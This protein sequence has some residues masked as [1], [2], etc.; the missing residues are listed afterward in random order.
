M[1]YLIGFKNFYKCYNVPPASTTI[2]KIPI[3]FLQI[4]QKYIEIWILT[5]KIIFHSK[6]K[7][8]T[9]SL[10]YKHTIV[11]FS[12]SVSHNESLF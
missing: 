12:K 5:G 4:E 9:T 6:C 7:K 8:N 2:K 3:Y 11:D 10:G 1:I